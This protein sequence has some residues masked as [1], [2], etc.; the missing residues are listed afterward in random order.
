M[1]EAGELKP[2]PLRVFPV[3]QAR[4]AFRH[5]AQAKHIGKIVLVPAEPNSVRGRIFR[6]DG[7]H[8]V[9]G[10]LGALGL[11]VAEWMANRGAGRIVLV[12]RSEPSVGARSRIAALRARGVDAIASRADVS[13]FGQVERIVAE[14]PQ[15]FPLRGIVHAA[16]VLEDATLVNVTGGQLRRVMDPKVAGAWNVH[17]ATLHLSLD[18]FVL[19]SSAASVVGSPG[20]ASYGAANAFLDSLGAY[21]QSLDMPSL[22][23]NWGP[24]AG[25]GMAAGSA[26]RFALLGIPLL[27]PAQALRALENELAAGRSGQ[28]IIAASMGQPQLK[29]DEQPRVSATNA[30]VEAQIVDHLARVSGLAPDRIERDRT[31]GDLGIDSLTAL[32]LMAE[33]EKTLHLKLPATMSAGDLTVAALAE[34]VA[35]QLAT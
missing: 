31:L 2:L 34:H 21:R 32:E 29:T 16:G 8:L 18:F 28:V 26:R 4:E 19:F 9:T 24:W 27:D 3:Q 30:S 20:Q 22:V 15:A 7:T 1:V 14:T 12:G 10:G 23:V 6:R 11:E 25:E 5:M 13:D 33:L 35:R 17:R